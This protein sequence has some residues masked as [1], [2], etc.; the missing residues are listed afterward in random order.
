MIVPLVELQ[1]HVGYLL[2]L[3]ASGTYLYLYY[4]KLRI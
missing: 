1:N 2:L 4:F 3:V